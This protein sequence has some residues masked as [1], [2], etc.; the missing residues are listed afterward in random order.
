MSKATKIKRP[1]NKAERQAVKEA[2]EY[3]VRIFGENLGCFQK[4]VLEKLDN[5]VWRVT[6]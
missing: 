3:Y 1:L 5:L 2:L 6:G 4:V